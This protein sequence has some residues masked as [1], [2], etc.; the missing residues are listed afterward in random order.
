MLDLYGNLP[1]RSIQTVAREIL[2]GLVEIHS[3]LSKPHG[4]LTSREIVIDAKG[5]LKVIRLV[6]LKSDLD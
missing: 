4:N 3:K 2:T 1:E 5:T 6:T